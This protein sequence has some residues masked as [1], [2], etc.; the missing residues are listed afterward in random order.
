MP[1]YKYKVFFTLSF[2]Y[3]MNEK[4]KISKYFKSDL[5]IDNMLLKYDLNV[6][7]VYKKWT[8]FFSKVSIDKLNPTSEFV[9]SLISEK[10]SLL[11]E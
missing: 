2:I 6:M 5:D 3:E 9:N 8:K 11:I 7:N 1:N 10:K 4:K